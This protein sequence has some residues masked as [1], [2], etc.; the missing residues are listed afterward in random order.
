MAPVSILGDDAGGILRDA[1]AGRVPQG[2]RRGGLTAHRFGRNVI[3][4]EVICTTV[5]PIVPESKFTISDSRLP[6]SATSVSTAV[7]GP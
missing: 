3:G 1:A 2:A 7:R 4:Q 5:M 6:A